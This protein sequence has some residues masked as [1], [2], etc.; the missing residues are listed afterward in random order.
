MCLFVCGVCVFV[1]LRVCVRVF[2]CVC[3]R[4]FVFIC[5]SVRV[6]SVR[7]FGCKCA[8]LRRW[9]CRR[10]LMTAE[11]GVEVEVALTD[12]AV[13]S[14]VLLVVVAAEEVDCVCLVSV[15]I[16]VCVSGSNLCDAERLLVRNER[17]LRYNQ[18]LL[19]SSQSFVLRSYRKLCYFFCGPS[20][21]SQRS[22]RSVHLR[23]MTGLLMRFT[24]ISRYAV[25]L[26]SDS[27]AFNL[28]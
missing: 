26:M 23:T 18:V 10:W 28:S 7:S 6:V 22:R 20:Y 4:V 25:K 27:Q 12:A 16:L 2:V 5:V 9:W 1:C 11:L 14:V 3:K 24:T 13:A 15:W 8:L 21:L 19:L 17:M